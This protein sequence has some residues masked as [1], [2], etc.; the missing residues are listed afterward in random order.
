M[1]HQWRVQAFKLTCSDSELPITADKFYTQHM[2]PARP[3]GQPTLD[4]KKTSYKQIGK[5]IKHMYKNKVRPP[6]RG[7][8]S[9]ARGLSRL[10]RLFRGT[11]GSSHPACV[12]SAPRQ[13]PPTSGRPAAVRARAT[14]ACMPPPIA[15]HGLWRRRATCAT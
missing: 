5:F 12:A 7:P 13:P 3:A 14:A 11:R 10:R 1:Y 15:V 9:P 2:Q 6:A 4:A 8:R